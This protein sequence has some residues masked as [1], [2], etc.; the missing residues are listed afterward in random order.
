M[1]SDDEELQIL[2]NITYDGWPETLFQAREFDREW[3]QVIELYW[4]DHRWRIGVQGYLKK[5]VLTLLRW[6]LSNRSCR[7]IFFK[8][9]SIVHHIMLT[10]N[11]E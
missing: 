2:S 4:I 1:T 6:F 11:V 3:K 9:F 7:K 8:L 5:N 10:W